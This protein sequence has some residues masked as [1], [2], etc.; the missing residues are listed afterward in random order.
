VGRSPPARGRFEGINAAFIDA[1]LT[2]GATVNLAFE[3][4]CGRQTYR[5]VAQGVETTESGGSL[6]DPGALRLRIGS[7]STLSAYRVGVASSW[8]ESPAAS[9]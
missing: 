4:G 8:A 9:R 6:D 5:R 3:G 1:K 2:L 7:Y